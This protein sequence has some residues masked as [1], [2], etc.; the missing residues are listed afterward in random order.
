MKQNYYRFK[1]ENLIK[2]KDIVTMYVFYHPKGYVSYP[3][4]HD[5]YEFNFCPSGSFDVEIAGQ[6]YHLKKNDILFIKPNDLHSVK[7][8][9]QDNPIWIVSFSCRSA[10]M[11]FFDNKQITVSENI[12]PML[13]LLFTIGRQYFDVETPG[14]DKKMYL[15][16]NIPLGGLQSIKNLVELFLI[17]LLKQEQSESIRIELSNNTIVK[18]IEMFLE[19]AIDKRITVDD[20]AAEIGYSKSYLHR[21]FYQEKKQTILAYFLKLKINRAKKLIASQKYN[22]TEIAEM[23]GFNTPNYF[24]KTFKKY[25]KMTPSQYKKSVL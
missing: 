2:I 12:L 23:L 7:T 3:E 15:Q 17:E 11:G 8:C 9:Y 6:T 22:F 4:K 5:F 18:Q 16:E 1:V 10:I 13:N 25:A 19:G 21:V 14:L 20:I 24:T